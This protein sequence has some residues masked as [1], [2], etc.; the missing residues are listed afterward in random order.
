MKP[1]E[2]RSD[3]YE[4]SRGIPAQ[5][6]SPHLPATFI[7][8][9]APS[10]IARVKTLQTKVDRLGQDVLSPYPSRE[11]MHATVGQRHPAVLSSSQGDLSRQLGSK[12]AIS[13]PNTG[14]R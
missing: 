10:G 12:A 13:H 7:S 5:Y 8:F 11:E 9:N 1:E 6:L 14:K 4:F 3:V 2:A